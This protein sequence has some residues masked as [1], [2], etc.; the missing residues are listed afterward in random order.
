MT[1]LRYLAP[2]MT[3]TTASARLLTQ[4]NPAMAGCLQR[5]LVDKR[6]YDPSHAE[7]AMLYDENTHN[8]DHSESSTRAAATA[9]LETRTRPERFILLGG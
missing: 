8:S 9:K 4:S 1:H 7:N 5:T 3:A 2:M 6:E